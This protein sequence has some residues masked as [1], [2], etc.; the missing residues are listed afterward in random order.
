M[1]TV[2]VSGKPETLR[3]ASAYGRI[4]LKPETVKAIKEGRV[5][6]GD[7][8]SACRLA[9]IMGAKKTPELLPFCHP[10]S[11]EH[12]EVDVRV[13]EDCLEV[14]SYVKGVGRTG[15]EMEALTAVSVALLTVYDMCKGMDDSMTIEEIRLISKEGGKSQWGRNLEGIR[16]RV[17]SECGMKELIEGKLSALGA[18]ISEEDFQLTIST[19]PLEFSEVWGVSA[20]LNQKLFSLFPHRLRRGV[21]VGLFEGKPCVEIQEEMDIVQSFFENFGSL[22]GNWVDGEAL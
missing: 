16:V 5:P 21:R 17:L 19:L 7:V 6:K 15:Y 14:F 13:E 1:K 11:F 12:V 2:D 8:L 3:T 10:L 18:E 22:I 4:R 20:V 9:G